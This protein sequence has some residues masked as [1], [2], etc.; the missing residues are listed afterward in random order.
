MILGWT[1]W[2]PTIIWSIYGASRK[3]KGQQHTNSVKN[4]NIESMGFVALKQHSEKLKHQGFSAYLSQSLTGHEN[5]LKADTSIEKHPET[6][7][8]PEKKAH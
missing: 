1:K 8:Q 6:S 5:D 2:T 7:Q 4:I 3:I